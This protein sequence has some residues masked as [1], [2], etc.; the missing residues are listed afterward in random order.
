MGRKQSCEWY[1]ISDIRVYERGDYFRRNVMLMNLIKQ[2][3]RPKRIFEFA[4]SGG[5]LANLILENIE[6]IEFYHH[7]DFTNI[8]VGCA[9]SLL[10]KYENCVVE[11]VDIDKEYNEINFSVYDT[12]ICISFEHL[13]HDL[14]IISR[15]PKNSLFI[16]CVPNFNAY[17]HVR[18]FNSEE[19]IFERYTSLLE[20]DIYSY[21][22]QSM[23]VKMKNILQNVN[24]K[25]NIKNINLKK[26]LQN[27]RL[28]C[29][30]I[31]YH[32]FQNPVRRV[33]FIAFATRTSDSA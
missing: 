15:I 25:N 5:F 27:A 20:M 2:K 18:Y 13:E 6:G 32:I 30:D 17:T 8:A 21:H 19:K 31:P 23:N 28:L 16:F 12:F 26:I 22:C 3:C 7:T 11:K 9:K 1:E 14:E 4:G 29:V 10:D 33:K 24:V